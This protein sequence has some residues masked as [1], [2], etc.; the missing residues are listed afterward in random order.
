M[1]KGKLKRTFKAYTTKYIP[2]IGDIPSRHGITEKVLYRYDCDHC[3]RTHEIIELAVEK[4]YC[5]HCNHLIDIT[6]SCAIDQ[7]GNVINYQDD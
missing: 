5:C 2:G 1:Y 7:Q 3:G 6:P 4:F